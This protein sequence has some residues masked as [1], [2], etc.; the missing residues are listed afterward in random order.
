[1]ASITQ[2]I[3]HVATVSDNEV[4]HSKRDVIKARNARQL[5]RRRGNPP[6]AKLKRALSHGKITHYD[7]HLTDITRATEIYGARQPARPS[8][9]RI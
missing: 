5:Q 6:D 2:L 1:M 9:S 8:R 3:G 7:I 4:L